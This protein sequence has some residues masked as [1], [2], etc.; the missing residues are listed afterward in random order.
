MKLAAYCISSLL[1]P[2][3]V[4]SFFI[5]HVT[6]IEFDG[7][8]YKILELI[9]VGSSSQVYSAVKLKENPEHKRRIPEFV[10]VK[11]VCPDK[12]DYL[13]F[14]DKEVISLSRLNAFES[15]NI[16][17]IFGVSDLFK[18][19]DRTRSC[20]F[21]ILSRAGKDF[22]RYCGSSEEFN[23]PDLDGE[24]PLK[25]GLL[26]FEAFAVSASLILIETLETI[27]AAGITHGDI[28][29]YNIALSFPRGDQPI[30]LDFGGSTTD[31][32]TTGTE[33]SGRLKRDFVDM[34]NLIISFIA[35]RVQ[36]EHGKD[37]RDAV[38]KKS[39]LYR[40]IDTC[41]SMDELKQKLIDFFLEVAGINWDQLEQKHIVYQKI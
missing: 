15:K 5:P 24:I 26:S 16:V 20:R 11:V 32:A 19:V 35:Q 28:R 6:R 25:Q 30:F 40:R 4:T 10:A 1:F 31:D 21:V 12:E 38:V 9:D 17:K 3:L 41:N 36:K 39:K 33:F 29:N 14:I 2:D 22:D 8:H 34:K 27:H 7:N 37:R 18:T 13:K 23:S